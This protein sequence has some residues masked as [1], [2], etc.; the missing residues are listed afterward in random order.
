MSS[1]RCNPKPQTLGAGLAIAF[2]A[3]KTGKA[4]DPA[5]GLTQRRGLGRWARHAV[6]E[7]YK[8]LPLGLFEVAAGHIGGLPA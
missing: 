5:H 6:V 2:V 7:G 1:S 4:C 8:S 3:Q